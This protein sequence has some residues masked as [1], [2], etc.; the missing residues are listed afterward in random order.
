MRVA[1]LLSSA[2]F[3]GCLTN[4]GEGEVED[5]LVVPATALAT[6]ASLALPALTLS[7]NPTPD[8][9]LQV[10]VSEPGANGRYAVVVENVL[11]AQLLAQD[12]R[13]RTGTP[14]TLSLAALP[15]GLYLVRLTNEQGQTAL[16]RVVRQ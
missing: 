4:F 3:G 16:R 7:P 8:G 14:A 15:A 2:T 5:Y 12:L 11:G 9:N 13:L 10:Q 1:V 6:Q